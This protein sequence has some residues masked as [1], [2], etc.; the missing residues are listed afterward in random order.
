LLHGYTPTPATMLKLRA[1]HIIYV[2]TVVVVK[3]KQGDEETSIPNV[4]HFS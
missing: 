4:R 3:E 1:P 2:F